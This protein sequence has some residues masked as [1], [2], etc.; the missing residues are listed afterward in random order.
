VANNSLFIDI[1]I[2]LWAMKIER[3]KGPMGQ[4]TPLDMDGFVDQGIVVS[5]D[6]PHISKSTLTGG[7]L[8]TTGSLRVRDRSALPGG[9]SLACAGT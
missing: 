9:S 1:A 6:S 8:Q 4:L 5:A 2:V 3:K 7:L